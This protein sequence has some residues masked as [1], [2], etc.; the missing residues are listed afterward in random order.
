MGFVNNIVKWSRKQRTKY[1]TPLGKFLAKLRI[2]ATYLTILAFIVGVI[3]VYFLFRNNLY[4]I[5]LAAVHLI[6]DGLDG[7]VARVTK[8]T[9]VGAHLDNISDRLVVV[10]VLIKSYFYFNDY[11]VLIVLGIYILHHLIFILSDLKGKVVYGRLITLL[12]YALG[13]YVLGYFVIGILALYGLS[14]QFNYWLKKKFT[15]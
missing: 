1:F 2:K 5:I 4:F 3:A 7:V 12:L 13:F 11:F 10:L 8:V 15:T 14:Q 9:R 6:L